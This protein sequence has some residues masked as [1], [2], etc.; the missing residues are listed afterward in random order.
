[1]KGKLYIRKS[2]QE[3]LHPRRF[4]SKGNYLTFNPVQ[5]KTYQKDVR[6][7]SLHTRELVYKRYFKEYLS[8]AGYV[9]NQRSLQV[10]DL[11]IRKI[12]D[13][14]LHSADSNGSQRLINNIR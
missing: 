6:H 9:A 10:K 2:I 12:L 8:F 3:I 14:R 5:K 1:V 7:E 4:Q 11:E 13:A